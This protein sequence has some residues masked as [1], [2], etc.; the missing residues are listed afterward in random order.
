MPKTS[1]ASALASAALTL[2]AAA[3]LAHASLV[4]S[5]LAASGLPDVDLKIQVA[6][7]SSA[8]KA[9][10]KSEAVVTLTP[11]SGIHINQYPPIR[12]TL[13]NAPPV[14]FEPDSYKLGL[15][16]MPDNPEK[17]PFEKIDPIKVRFRVAPHA[18]DAKVAIK[19]KLKFYYCVKASGYCAPGT[20]DVTFT[21]PVAA[22]D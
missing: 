9:G 14:T 7:A 16:A 15:D 8:V 6:L 21:V 11:P 10:S 19:G 17:N 4:T 22:G 12:L 5:T 13:E 1:L 20:K 2:L 18:S 3:V